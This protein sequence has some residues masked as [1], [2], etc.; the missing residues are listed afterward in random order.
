MGL[1]R[2]FNVTL[3]FRN[4]L[5]GGLPKSKELVENYIKAKF[6]PEVVQDEETVPYITRDLELTEETEKVTTGFKKDEIGIYL[7]SYIIKAALKEY[8]SVLKLTTKKVSAGVKQ[9]T[10]HGMFVKGLLPVVDSVIPEPTGLP[11]PDIGNR[12]PVPDI[13]NR[14]PVPDIGNRGLELTGENIYAQP[15]RK[16]P[17]GMDDFAGRVNTPQ[18]ARSI[19]KSS[20]FLFQPTF[21]F[22]LWILEVRMG[23]TEKSFTQDDVRMMFELG[24]EAGIGS[25]R[26]FES[27]KYDVEGMEEVD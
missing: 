25:N 16:E 5:Y 14:G 22:Q 9:T 8:A 6:G 15:L 13:V 26:T 23:N 11:V 20:E 10:Q 27:G 12:G 17:D 2:K 24:Q 21:Q 18:G 4:K 1:Y 3:Q 19:L 7:G